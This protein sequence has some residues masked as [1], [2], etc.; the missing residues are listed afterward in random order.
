MEV[1]YWIVKV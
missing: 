1:V